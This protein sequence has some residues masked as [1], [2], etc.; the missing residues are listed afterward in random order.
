M[1]TK[2]LNSLAKYV[3]KG[4][5]RTGYDFVRYR[6]LPRDLDPRIASIVREACEYSMTSAQRILTLCEAVQYI[7][8]NEIEGDI[9][10]CGVWRGGSM[11]AAIKTLQ[12]CG[13]KDRTCHL[14][15][16]FAGMT[17]PTADDV[18][19]DGKTAAE[20]LSSSDRNEV[21]SF[22]CYAPLEGVRALLSTTGYNPDR[23]VFVKGRVEDTLP[24]SMPDRIALLRLDTDWYESTKHELEHL[25]PKLVS[26]GVL[27]VD[28]Y[29]HWQGARRAVDEY[30]RENRLALFL[31]RIDYSGRCA[32][33]VR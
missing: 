31:Q 18:E 17:P 25:Y 11:L 22:W 27:I 15:D 16:T 6:D 1:S 20:L 21:D 8:E 19:F 33:K 29:G 7:V 4:V 5:R 32:I 10:E 9:V 12:V 26:G 24:A 3:R 28:D 23:M 13:E 14:F 2:L 30:V